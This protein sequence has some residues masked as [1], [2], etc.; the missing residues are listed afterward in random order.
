MKTRQ[1]MHLNQ[2]VPEVMKQLHR[3]KPDVAHIKKRIETLIETEY[4][5]RDESDKRIFNYLA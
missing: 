1:R 3:F 5:E 4:L 2:L